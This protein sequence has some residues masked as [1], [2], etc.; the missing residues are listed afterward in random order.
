MNKKYL[1]HLFKQYKVLFV[2][3]SL[4]TMFIF[5]YIVIKNING[6]IYYDY[7][8]S[9]EMTL[10][11]LLLLVSAI[12]YAFL[13]SVKYYRV[14]SIDI[15]DSLPM[16]KQKRKLIEVLFGWLMFAIPY[17]VGGIICS[18][19]LATLN[20]I[21]FNS[22]AIICG[23]LLA[24]ITII[25]LFN[26]FLLSICS[27]LKEGIVNVTMFLVITSYAFIA[28]AQFISSC[29]IN[30]HLALGMER[31]MNTF[32]YL[33][34]GLSPATFVIMP[35]NIYIGSTTV[36]LSWFVMLVLV[37]LPIILIYVI[38]RLAKKRKA[39]YAGMK[40]KCFPLYFIALAIGSFMLGLTYMT[41]T[42]S[43]IA[44]LLVS[45][46]F[47]WV[48]LII[49]VLIYDRSKK[50]ILKSALVILIAYVSSIAF[51]Y[52]MVQSEFLGHYREY[53]N[54]SEKLN[55]H[56]EIYYSENMNDNSYRNYTI[57]ST[58]GNKKFRKA[59]TMMQDEFVDSFK[60]IKMKGQST[61]DSV[62]L[63]NMGS[64]SVSYYV[65]GRDEPNTKSFYYQYAKL[66]DIDRWISY[67][68]K[69]GFYV[70]E[71]ESN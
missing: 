61:S 35:M 45:Q 28:I 43:S 22:F 44:V 54:V 63:G 23:Y 4:I 9:N 7:S 27:S 29:S 62:Y 20:S 53:K 33:V 8:L 16:Q 50:M 51:Q 12:A 1:I 64:I 49:I 15:N 30:L 65:D 52:A 68:K 46:A 34:F 3:Q 38:Y 36:D 41:N 19:Y 71:E 26:V 69:N 6:N 47:I 39:E 42:G 67:F 14:R 5:P 55:P 48:G 11:R 59:V 31:M 13:I 32:G 37:I 24:C 17:I 58:S 56:V 66:D 40:H 25:Y 18:I 57:S 70:Q 10:I 21:K 2:I 60:E